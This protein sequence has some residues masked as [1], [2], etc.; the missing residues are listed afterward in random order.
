MSLLPV[1]EIVLDILLLHS[2]IFVKVDIFWPRKFKYVYILILRFIMLEYFYY[3]YCHLCIFLKI[4]KHIIICTSHG[5]STRHSMK[6]QWLRMPKK[7]NF[8]IKR[9]LNI[10]DDSRLWPVQLGRYLI[11][12]RELKSSI[13]NCAKIIIFVLFEQS[14]PQI[15]KRQTRS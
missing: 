9:Q 4:E 15:N 11:I 12:C 14:L 2:Y 1:I 7:I 6:W 10:K 5:G 13:W 8:K 3:I